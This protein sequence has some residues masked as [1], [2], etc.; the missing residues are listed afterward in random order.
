MFI[1]GALQSFAWLAALVSLQRSKQPQ[2]WLVLASCHLQPLALGLV[3][4]PRA[5]AGALPRE[6]V[7][8]AVALG[9]ELAFVVAVDWQQAAQ[10]A[11]LL[12]NPLNQ[13]LLGE[14]H[15]L[16]NCSRKI[17]SL[18]NISSTCTPA[19]VCP[20]VLWSPRSPCSGICTMR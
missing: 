9:L 19:W 15:S 6:D 13:P 7:P 11:Q 17:F 18:F 20:Q 3:V 8:L 1:A 10:H 5:I 12:S 2:H 4:L 14:E 16:Y